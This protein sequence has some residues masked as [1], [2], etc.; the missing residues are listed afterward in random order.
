MT[1]SVRTIVRSLVNAGLA[2]VMA[3]VCVS[4]TRQLPNEFGSSEPGSLLFGLLHLTIAIS[5]AAASAGIIRRA[6]LTSWAVG[7]CGTAAVGL[8]LA[9]PL[10]TPMD[11]DDQQS[12][13]L[14]AALIG[15]AAAI[16]WWLARRLRRVHETS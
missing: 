9:Q 12:I 13:W 8:V 7:L 6:R 1:P 10:Y 5:A 3:G 16:V 2:A 4:S 11:S 14:G 15:V